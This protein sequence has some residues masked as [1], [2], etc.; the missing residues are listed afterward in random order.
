MS[1]LPPWP[2]GLVAYKRT[3]EFDETTVP[4]GLLRD[5]A[6]KAG[7]WARLHILEGRLDFVDQEGGGTRALGPGI[8]PVI[9]PERLHRVAPAG[10]VRFFVE[11]C[12]AEGAAPPPND[13]SAFPHR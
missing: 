6:T 8:H 12:R 1:N 3:P 2:P 5:H 7:T 4:A 13:G 9:F 10:R 11:F